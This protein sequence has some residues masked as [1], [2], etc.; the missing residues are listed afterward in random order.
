MAK[1]RFEK[2]LLISILALSTVLLTVSDAL[3][4]VDRWIYDLQLPLLASPASP[5]I[6]IIE[7]DQKSLADFGRWPWPRDIHARLLE[8]LARSKPRAIALDFIFS[9][10]DKSH[11]EADAHLAQ[12][13][14][15]ARP[16]VLPV[17]V[18]YNGQTLVETLPLPDYAKHAALGHANVDL[19]KDGI[20][21]SILLQAGLGDRL[22][23]AMPLALYAQQHPEFLQALPGLRT[24]TP[25]DSLHGDF[26]VWLPFFDPSSDFARLSYSEVLSG[27]VPARVFDGKYVLVGLTASGLER[28]LPAPLAV[29]GRPMTGVE[30]IAAGLDGLLK[31]TLWQPLPGIW[32]FWASLAIAGCSVWLSTRFSPR[33]LPPAILALSAAI[34]CGSWLLLRLSHYWFAPSVALCVLWFSY[35]L[36]SWRHFEKLIQSLFAE[37][38][39][40]FVTLNA[41]ADGV[42]TTTPDGVIDYMNAA[43]IDIVGHRPPSSSSLNIDRIFTLEIRDKPFA[44]ADLIRQSIAENAPLKYSHCRL[45]VSGQHQITANLGIAP[46]LAGKGVASGAVISIND[47]GERMLMAKMLLQKTEEQAVMREL[48]NRAEQMSLAKSQFLSQM[49]H[50]LRTPLNAVIGFAQL[51]QMDD[52]EHPLDPYHLDSVQ[53]ILKAGQHLLG[54]INELLD[55]AKIESGK[56]AMNIQSVAL[57]DLIGD[58]T[59]LISPLARSKGLNLAVQNPLA[60]DVLLQVDP[61]RAKQILLNFLS[62]AVKYNSPQGRIDLHAQLSGG[63][64]VRISITDTGQGVAEQEQKLLFQSFQRLGAESSEIEGT[65]IGLAITKQLAELMDG[66]VGVSSTPGVGS[67]FWVEFP[68]ANEPALLTHPVI[69]PAL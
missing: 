40:A 5:E 15:L 52:P 59:A 16:V 25:R 43:A 33:W 3:W 12:A 50:E 53:E 39:R 8:F 24:E 27:K 58:C 4:R 61:K 46:L 49:S 44:I 68:L 66:G 65:G 11:P 38:K 55:L 18:E 26:R 7:V 1:R 32:Q 45:T 41:I 57:A 63:D 28:E 20:S 2:P 62:N 17:V 19:D 47:I 31:Q 14:T 37:R 21:R 36:R 64:R 23:P 10:A 22:W 69:D 67:T 13:L 56:I 42:I 54:L 51:L 35:P 29:G 60:P 34:L 9:E 30:F 6:I 48:I